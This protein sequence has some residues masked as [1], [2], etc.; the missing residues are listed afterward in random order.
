MYGL[1]A[2]KYKDFVVGLYRE[3]IRLTWAGRS[4]RLRRSRR[5]RCREPRCWSSHR[6]TAASRPTFNVIQMNYSN[7]HKLAWRQR[8]IIRKKIQ[9]KENSRSAGQPHRRSLCLMQGP[10]ELSLVSGQSVLIP[11]ATLLSNPG[12]AS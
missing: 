11:N 7:L 12:Q 1:G 8:C 5:N 10:W 4:P 3:R 6:V 2:V 9:R